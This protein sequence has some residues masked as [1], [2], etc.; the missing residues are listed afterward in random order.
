ML[1]RVVT[2]C[3]KNASTIFVIGLTIF[4]YGIYSIQTAKL[5]IFPEFAPPQIVIQTE[6]PGFSSELTELLVS[7]PIEKS[8]V[9]LLG[10][11]SIRS[12]STPGLSVVTIIFDDKNSIFLNRQLVNERLSLISNDLPKN[13]YTPEITP[14]TSSASSILGFGITSETRSLMDLR[15]VAE[16]SIRPSIMGTVGVAD[17]HIFG[18]D[19]R[20]RQIEIIPKLLHNSKISIE[21]VIDSVKKNSVITAIGFLENNNQRIEASVKTKN[22]SISDLEAIAVKSFDSRPILLGDI[23]TISD[24]PAPAISVASINGVQGVFIMAQGQLGADTYKTTLA[25]ETKLNELVP[26]FEREGVTLHRNLFRPANFI[27]EAVTNVQRDILIGASLVIAV[28]FG[29]LYNAKTAL[30]SA[31]AI[32]LS[33]LTS[34]IILVFQGVA[35]NIMVLGG[36]VIALGEVVDD[37]IIDAENVFRRLR[38]NKTLSNPLSSASVII[39]ASLEVRHSIIIAT[40]IVVLVFTPLLFLPDVTGRLFKPLGLAYIYALGSSLLIAITITPALCYLLLKNTS[41]LKIK[42]SPTITW[43]KNN[44]K[45]ILIK[46][47]KAPKEL[48]GIVIFLIISS[49]AAI[50][51][52]RFEFIPELREGHY[53]VHM[54][55]IPGTSSKEMLR[56]GNIVTKRIREIDGVKSTTQWV[57]RAENGADTFGTHYSEIQVEV[58]PLTASKQE[59]IV[60]EI[61]ASLSKIPDQ[62]NSIPFPGFVFGINTFLAERIEETVSGYV[63]DFVIEVVGLNL[64]T[65]DKD[66][67]NIAHLLSSTK[68]FSNVQIVSPLSAPQLKISLKDQKISER[69][70]NSEEI[71]RIF[72]LIFHGI[73]VAEIIDGERKIPIRISINDNFQN[74]ID[75]IKNLRFISKDG[76]SFKI[77][78][79]AKLELETGRSK[80]L[81]NSGKRVQAITADIENIDFS[82]LEQKI[83]KLIDNNI[84]L[85]Q[86]NY[87]TLS[88]TSIETSSNFKRL[89]VASLIS[90]IGVILLL[91]FAMRTN[92]NLIIVLLN[93]PFCLIGGVLAV[94]ING[95]WLSIGAM[96]GFITLFGITIR[97]SIMLVSHYHYLVETEKMVWN[98]STALKGA[99]DRLPSIL[100]TAIVTGLGLLPLV[101]G[102]GEPGREIEGPMASI[103]V[104]GLITSTILNL[105][106]FPSLFLR[107]G[108]FSNNRSHSFIN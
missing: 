67:K 34:I 50:N 63:S 59:I 12:Q 30:I 99:S 100:M 75:L 69:G 9:G 78:E 7:K 4:F 58:G 48:I 28:L 66:A 38:E 55:A 51:L 40:L 87:L 94:F 101:L 76:I 106:I 37:A 16:L 2:F 10:I 44:Y 97:N 81:R 20:N 104:S 41:S 46:I 84:K 25:L 108:D 71:N 93:L 103:I 88:G 14:I 31:I 1:K 77:S 29:F 83:R 17:I 45:H 74:K 52:F 61:K 95:G 35:L 92:R 42:D 56:V 15:E 105:L 70:L 91:K 54:T 73:E 22:Q 24:Q 62:G 80:I 23:S 60:N 33:L 57:G 102:S 13:V 82:N 49:L 64:T 3:V 5:D 53:I 65:I 36:L 11:K 39:K 72:G 98:F 43:L 96:V 8:L 19:V 90:F 26:M 85:S 68:G 47:E 86:N 18:G 89:L 32:P 107:Y 79:V 6:A 27:E 21:D